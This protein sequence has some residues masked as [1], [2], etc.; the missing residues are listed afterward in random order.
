MIGKFIDIRGESSGR[1]KI[2]E[3]RFDG[4]IVS[5]DAREKDAGEGKYY[6]LKCKCGSNNWTDNG[7]HINEYECDSCGQ[8]VE[9]YEFSEPSKPYGMLLPE[10]FKTE[11]N[12]FYLHTIASP[13]PSRDSWSLPG[14]FS[15]W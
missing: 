12:Q 6:F 10:T 5:T 14:P 13:K 15:F 8:F 2:S 4:N 7:R 1:M 9:A 3:W 11:Q